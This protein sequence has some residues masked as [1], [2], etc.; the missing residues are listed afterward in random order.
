MLGLD[1]KIGVGGTLLCR[2]LLEDITMEKLQ[3]FIRYLR[4]KP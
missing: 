4:G 2:Y 1:A 3:T